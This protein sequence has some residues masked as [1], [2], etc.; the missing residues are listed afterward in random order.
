MEESHSTR[1]S[2]GLCIVSILLVLF[3]IFSF[4]EPA[5]AE[6]KNEPVKIQKIKPT[7]KVKQYKK[8]HVKLSWKKYKGVDE[9]VVYRNNKK[10][11]VTSK[12]HFVDRRK[13]KRRYSYKIIGRTKFK[14]KL[15]YTNYSNSKS[16][17]LYKRKFRVKAYAYSGG[18]ITAMGKKVKRGR[19]AVDPRVIRLG[20]W[21]YVN[22]YG[23]CQACDT[24]GAIKGK[25]VD[26]YMNSEGACNRWGVRYPKLYVLK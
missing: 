9:F 2:R 6:T 22:G 19:I 5:K 26:L 15:I 21:V 1:T 14:S 11:K 13:F 8:I 18:G 3:V 4:P 17:K 16:I 12:S 23:L 24:G 7:L 25:T 10:V 20:S